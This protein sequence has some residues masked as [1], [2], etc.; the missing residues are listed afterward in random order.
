MPP[1]HH[2]KN[3]EFAGKSDQFLNNRPEVGIG[4]QRGVQRELGPAPLRHHGRKIRVGELIMP[5]FAGDDALIQLVGP[6]DDLHQLAHAALPLQLHAQL[7]ANARTAAV[8][9]DHVAAAQSFRPVPRDGHPIVVLHEIRQLEPIAYRDVRRRLGDFL[10]QR[11]Q[12]VL[13]HELIR[14]Q[15]PIAVRRRRDLFPSFRDRRI[16][17]RCN[18]RFAQLPCQEHIHRIIRRV[19]QCAHTVRYADA[20]VEFHGARV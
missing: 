15:Q 9:P 17:Q 12:L 10:Q 6:E 13:R 14:L 8:A 11:L 20:T 3:F 1:R 7:L 16:F 19:S 5:A 2:I 4:W 18:R